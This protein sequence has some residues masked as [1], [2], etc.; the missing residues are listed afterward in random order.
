MA[1]GKTFCCSLITSQKKQVAASNMIERAQQKAKGR[2]VLPAL[3]LFRLGMK[4]NI[5]MFAAS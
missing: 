1:G 5:I 3:R 4:P 2:T